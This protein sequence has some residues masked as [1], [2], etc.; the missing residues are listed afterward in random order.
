MGFFKLYAVISIA[1]MAGYFACALMVA[2]SNSDQGN[3]E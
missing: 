3:K 1:F 2:G